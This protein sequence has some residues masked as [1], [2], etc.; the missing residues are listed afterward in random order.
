MNV[1]S[2]LLTLGSLARLSA[3]ASFGSTPFTSQYSGR[4][5]CS[6]N[7]CTVNTDTDAE[8]ASGRIQVGAESG[9]WATDTVPACWAPVAAGGS[10]P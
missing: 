8:V 1:L 10:E 9:G 4:Y 3:E 6:S 7:R 5:I 2:P